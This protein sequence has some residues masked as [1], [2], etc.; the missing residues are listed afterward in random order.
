MDQDQK[1][2]LLMLAAAILGLVGIVVGGFL[3]LVGQLRNLDDEPETYEAVELVF[4][5]DEEEAPAP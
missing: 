4:P 2:I 3:W 5:E 1:R